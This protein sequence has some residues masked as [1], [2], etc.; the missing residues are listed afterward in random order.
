MNYLNYHTGRPRFHFEGEPPPPAPPPP[1]PPAPPAPAW[2]AGIEAET[3]GFWQ[4]KGYDLTDPKALATKLT[5]QYRAAEKHIGAPPDQIIRMPKADARPEEIAAM[6]QRL[7]APKEA[8]EYDFSGIKFAGADLEPAFADAMRAGL[9]AAF[10]PKDKAGA[11]VQSVVKFLES[12]DTTESTLNTAKLAEERGKLEKNW[13]AKDSNTYRFNLLAAKEGANRL[14]I[15]EAGVA[16]LENL[17][18]YSSVMDALRK[19]GNARK[20]DV[21]V[22]SG[23]S[24][25]NGKV[26]TREGAMSR[27]QELFADKAWVARL[28][29]G[30]QQAKTEWKNLNMMI[31]GEA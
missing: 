23:Q 21:F 27:K 14:G 10:V 5:E 20:E 6:W 9:A 18:G 8:K 17:M 2:H 25:G 30:D 7:G 1:A 29:S 22:E 16:A 15:D 11:I 24:A 31:D 3:L 19:I 12:A 26:T 13:G 28:N 4:N